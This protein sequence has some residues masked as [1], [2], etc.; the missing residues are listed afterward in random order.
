MPRRRFRTPAPASWMR[1]TWPSRFFGLSA[2]R[3][4]LLQHARLGFSGEQSHDDARPERH[5]AEY[6]KS[7]ADAAAPDRIAEDLRSQNGG[8]AQPCG[9]GRRAERAYARRVKLGRIE[10]ERE[11]QRDR[12]S[13]R[14]N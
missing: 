13:T 7:A 3:R 10:V 6:Q 4:N 1:K 5:Q 11:R 8:Q 2:S 12:K 9:A 14:L